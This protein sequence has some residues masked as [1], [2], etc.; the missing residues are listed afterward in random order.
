MAEEIKNRTGA[1]VKHSNIVGNYAIWSIFILLGVLLDQWTKHLAIVHLK[2][3]N[4]G[5]VVLIKKFLQFT[6]V[7]N[8]GAAWGIFQ[9][10]PIFLLIV[11]MVMIILILSVYRRIPFE[12]KYLPMRILAALIIM[13]AIGNMVDRA[14]RGYVVDFFEFAFIDFPVFN[15]ADIYV[16][17][18]AG[19]FIVFGLFY[20][21][22]Q[23][24]EFIR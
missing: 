10:K 17:L 20:Y 8:R 18:G 21:K 15:V 12:K 5:T 22:D 4:A 6:Y 3:K 16:T 24:F 19:L 1:N 7:E 9:G 14:M 2:E 23:D 11:G 13:G